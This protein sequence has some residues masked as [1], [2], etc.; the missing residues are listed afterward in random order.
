MQ[1]HQSRIAVDGVVSIYRPLSRGPCA[2]A[3][4]LLISSFLKLRLIADA[5]R[6]VFRGNNFSAEVIENTRQKAALKE[7]S[8][9]EDVADQVKT[10]ALSKSITGQNLVIDCGIAI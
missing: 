9:V 6:H 1:Q 2:R 10:F 3:S 5:R 8:S 4:R 7:I